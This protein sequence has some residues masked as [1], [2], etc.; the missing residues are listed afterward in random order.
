MH[1]AR[2]QSS[3]GRLALLELLASLG[4][5][6]GRLVNGRHV[7]LGVPGQGRR[8]CQLN[9]EVG[10]AVNRVRCDATLEIMSRAKTKTG[11]FMP[12]R[13]V[14]GCAVPLPLPVLLLL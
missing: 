10:T 14:S 9:L 3:C 13:L 11:T 8:E 5:V 1:E 4:E 2:P 6:E 7:A 12:V